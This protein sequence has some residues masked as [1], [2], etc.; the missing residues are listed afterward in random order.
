MVDSEAA[1]IVKHV[2]DDDDGIEAFRFL[3][4]RFDPHTALTK[5]HRPKAI[6]KSPE[7]SMAKKNTDVPAVLAKFED[8][9]LN[10]AEDY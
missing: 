5:A 3:H 1:G 4:C 10:Y 2:R 7:K 8:L 9:L 6:Q